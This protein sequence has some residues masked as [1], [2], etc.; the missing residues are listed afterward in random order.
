MTSKTVGAPLSTVCGTVNLKNFSVTIA[1]M[2]ERLGGRKKRKKSLR[3]THVHLGRED[4]GT[5]AWAP[6]VALA[7]HG[8]TSSTSSA[9]RTTTTTTTSTAAPTTAPPAPAR[10]PSLHPLPPHSTP[11]P[12]P[13]PTHPPHIPCPPN[14]ETLPAPPLPPYAR[15]AERGETPNPKPGETRGGGTAG[16]LCLCLGFRV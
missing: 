10:T 5:A 4:V 8:A 12:L 6:P 11:S 9:I 3:Y 16:G 1:C 2:D 13:P 14:G 15:A 7:R